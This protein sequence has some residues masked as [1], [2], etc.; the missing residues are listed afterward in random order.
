MDGVC[1]SYKHLKEVTD[2]AYVKRVKEK[3]VPLAALSLLP[4]HRLLCLPLPETH[5]P[6]TPLHPAS[7]CS[8]TSRGS[9]LS[10]VAFKPLHPLFLLCW[11]L[12][13]TSPS[14][15]PPSLLAS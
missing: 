5:L 2:R 1:Q 7:P 11:S 6:K 8:T 13:A 14:H 15:W 4:G 10:S 9:L 3:P 12:I